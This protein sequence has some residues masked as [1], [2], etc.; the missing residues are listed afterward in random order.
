MA[1]WIDT[2][3]ERNWHELPELDVHQLEKDALQMATAHIRDQRL[4]RKAYERKQNTP[5][6]ELTFGSLYGM[7]GVADVLRC[8]AQFHAGYMNTVEEIMRKL[9]D[10]TLPLDQL[11]EMRRA[12]RG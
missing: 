2:L 9:Q 5:M 4:R 12:Q 10:G 3:Y 7:G 6:S 8:A 1:D 11:E